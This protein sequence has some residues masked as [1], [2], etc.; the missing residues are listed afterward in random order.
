M[1]SNE[2]EKLE[3]TFPNM[4]SRES[5]LDNKSREKSILINNVTK[6]KKVISSQLTEKVKKSSIA[7]IIM[8]LLQ[9][10][11]V[12]RGTLTEPSQNPPNHCR[13][14]LQSINSSH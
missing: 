9:R 4:K 10:L 3:T 5:V 7:L 11:S 12:L 2:Y 8:Y 14:I 1:K 13:I 6:G